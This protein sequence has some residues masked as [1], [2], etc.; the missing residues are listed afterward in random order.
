MLVLVTSAVLLFAQ[1]GA[2]LDWKKNYA[3]ALQE[4]KKGDRYLVVH[5]S[6]PG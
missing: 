3:D 6:G 1:E 4:A 5:F 2:K